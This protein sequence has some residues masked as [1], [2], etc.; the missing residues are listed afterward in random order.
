MFNFGLFG[1]VLASLRFLEAEQKA[2]IKA[3]PRVIAQAGKPLT[4][5]WETLTR[6]YPREHRAV[7]GD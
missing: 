1:K 2:E 4:V 3:N 5:L 6:F 7:G